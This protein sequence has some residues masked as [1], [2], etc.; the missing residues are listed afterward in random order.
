MQN[1]IDRKYKLCLAISINLSSILFSMSLP[2]DA[3]TK[4]KSFQKLPNGIYF[5]SD[6]RLP[7]QPGSVYVIIK[8]N[9][10][11]FV[12]Y[13]YI[14]QSDA[15]CSSGT[16]NGNTL[17]RTKKFLGLESEKGVVTVNDPLDLSKLYRLSS[18][19]IS[20]DDRAALQGCI[21]IMKR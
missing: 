8:K 10:N 3:I 1:K 7:K 9:R 15:G 4:T 17:N 5:Y 14:Y 2:C 6:A 20:T 16:I 19:Q 21:E 11:N 12:T 13:G 18:Q